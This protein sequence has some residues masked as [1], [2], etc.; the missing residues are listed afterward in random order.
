MVSHK[1]STLILS[2]QFYQQ[3]T[4][5]AHLCWR[6]VGFRL[7]LIVD[8]TYKADTDRVVVVA[9]SVGTYSTLIATSLY[10]PIAFDDEVIPYVQPALLFVPLTDFTSSSNCGGR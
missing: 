4:Q 8:T 6:K 9:L 5:S 1:F 2:Q 7:T 10:G 3:T